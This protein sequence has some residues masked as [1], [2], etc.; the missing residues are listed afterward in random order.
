MKLYR[1][2]IKIGWQIERERERERE[3]ESLINENFKKRK[4]GESIKGSQSMYEVK[5][6]E[7][8]PH[9]KKKQINIFKTWNNNK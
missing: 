1:K 2:D 9:T 3:R 6:W 4:N 7:N 5:E 8:N